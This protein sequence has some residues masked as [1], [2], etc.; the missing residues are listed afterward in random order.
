MSIHDTNSKS[1]PTQSLCRVIILGST[2]SVGVQSIDVIN[3]LNRLH[4]DNSTA[5]RFQVVGLAARSSQGELFEQAQALGVKDVALCESSAPSSLNVRVG[6]GAALQLIQEV[7]CDLVVGAVVGVAGLDAI[8]ESLDRGIDVALANK[9]TL[10]AAGSLV[11]DAARRSGARIFPVDSEHAG[12]W[13]CLQSFAHE[14][15]APPMGLPEGVRK[16]TLTASGGPFR[17]QSRHEIQN[18]QIADA[19][20]HPNWSMG[21]KVTIDSATLMNKALELIEA[22]WLFGVGADQL[23]AVIH[24][25]S[26]IHA[27][28]ESNDGSVMAQLGAPDMKSPIQYA[29]SW[30]TRFDGSADRLDVT[31]HSRLDFVEIDPMRF[32]AIELAMNA[33]RIGKSA[34]AVLNASNEQAVHAY[35]NGDIN[36]G[37]IDECVQSAMDNIEFETISSLDDVYQADQRARDYVI[38][39]CTTRAE[40]IQ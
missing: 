35:L 21:T 20:N 11:V 39:L 32:P 34:G 9:E 28:V 38:Q 26:I 33:I 30:P 8:L 31:K 14:L 19:L 27:F 1:D 23:D 2:G 15:Y 29:M 6:K 36:F 40:H 16:I 18:A 4:K 17:N 24:P 7:E 22:H 13:Q 37:Q 3:H 10:V 25:Q 12:V 5:R